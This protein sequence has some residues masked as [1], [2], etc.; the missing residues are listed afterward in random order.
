MEFRLYRR[1]GGALVEA[2]AQFKY[3]VRP[4]YQMDD[5]QPEVRRKLKWARGV[6]VDW[7]RC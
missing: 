1:E 3:L 5:D 6:W 7:V 2:V 4:L